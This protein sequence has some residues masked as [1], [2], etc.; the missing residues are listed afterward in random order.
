METTK[1][2]PANTARSLRTTVP[3]SI[4][5]QLGLNEGDSLNWELDKD[6]GEWI[7]TVRKA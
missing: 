1:L 5:K 4:V 7:V 6:N 3:M 2:T